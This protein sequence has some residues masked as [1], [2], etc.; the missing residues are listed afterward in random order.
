MAFGDFENPLA[1]MMK[2]QAE[3]KKSAQE[4]QMKNMQF[5]VENY[6]KQKK[7]KEEMSK[8]YYTLM[9]GQERLKLMSERNALYQDR[10]K[11]E[12][13]ARTQITPYQALTVANQY[14]GNQAI[15]LPQNQQQDI[16]RVTRMASGLLETYGQQQGITPNNGTNNPP[17]TTNQ[18][19]A[20]QP[21][22]KVK[23]D[24][25]RIRILN[26]QAQQALSYGA[27]PVLVKKKLQEE[28]KKL[29]Y[30]L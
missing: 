19:T 2:Q 4:L 15:G 12:Q 27:D 29:G 17:A 24:P 6:N 26:A 21:D 8:D 3:L 10:L 20:K 25:N 11:Q 18:G 9:Q 14:Y 16:N 23:V 5:Q 13:K 30:A 7:Q 1:D 28:Y 22:T